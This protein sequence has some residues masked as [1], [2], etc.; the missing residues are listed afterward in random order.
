MTERVD[1]T[2]NYAVSFAHG[3]G[4]VWSG[5]Q[6]CVFAN[7]VLTGSFVGNTDRIKIKICLPMPCVQSL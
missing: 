2:G 3:V 1:K 7:T 4:K 6:M 5:P